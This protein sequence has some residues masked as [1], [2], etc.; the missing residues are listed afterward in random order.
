MIP[1]GSSA[2]GTRQNAV[3]KIATR[4]ATGLA[5]HQLVRSGDFV[6]IRPRHIM[7]HDNTAAVMPKFR[8]MMG[9]GPATPAR[10]RDPRQPVFAID[11]DI[12]N[13]SPENLG[14]Y[15][16]IEQFA[17]QQ[18][19]DFFPAG[20][21]IAHQIMIEQGYVIPGSLVVGSDS[22]SNIYG[23]LAALGTPVVRTDAA[24]VWA[25]GETWWQV[26]PVARVTLRGRLRPGVVGKDV[27]IA[28]CGMFKN[29]E[30][31]NHAVEFCGTGGGDADGGIAALSVDERLSIA[32]MTTEWGALAG[33][34]PFDATLLDWLLA[35]ADALSDGAR[36]PHHRGGGYTRSDVEGWWAS[37]RSFAADADAHYAIELEL[38]LATVVPH[39]AG[40]N[41]VRTIA[42]LPD[43]EP[44]RI[45]IQKAWLMSCVNGRSADLAEAAAVMRGRKVA[46]GVEFYLAAA[47]AEIEAKARASGVWASL[48]DAGAIELPPGCGTCIGLGRGLIRKGEVGVSSTNR[49]FEGRMGDREGQVYLASPAVVAASAIAGHLAAPIRFAPEAIRVAT[50]TVEAL[51]E[52]GAAATVEVIEGFPPVVRGRTLFLDRDHLNT[53]GIYAGKHTYNEAITPAEM[54]RVLFENYDPTFATIARPGDVIVGGRNFGTGSSREQAATA[55][56]HF[57]IPCV[58]A[59]SFSETYKRN[60]FNNGFVVFECPAL[61]AHLRAS[62]GGAS[63]PTRVG[64]DIAIDYRASSLRCDGRDFPFAPLSPVAQELVV[65]GGA[66]HLVARRLAARPA[67]QASLP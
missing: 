9:D 34:F 36:I 64:P 49:N 52:R 31:L 48:V 22:H 21:G 2:V 32:N 14:K 27:I 7:T 16:K 63:A 42:A 46:P 18:G 62:L 25:T 15:A 35:R 11:H 51:P 28:L 33:V 37:R 26:P 17:R 30:I 23:G 13:R 8:Q 29:D 56:K 3:E 6:M 59:I 40:P 57:G 55:L 58:I 67:T 60:A 66:E 44:K 24:S 50:R 5:Q 10:I 53:D 54:A 47:S 43:I 1:H 12:Q 41:D 45:A 19:V 38:D 20:T 61:V 65:A 39:V 4:Y